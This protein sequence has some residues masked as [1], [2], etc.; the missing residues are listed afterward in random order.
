MSDNGVNQAVA[1]SSGVNCD[2]PLSEERM[3]ISER[4]FVI[5]FLTSLLVA[6]PV[7]AQKQ[8]AQ[9]PRILSAKSVYFQN[10][11][12]SDAVGKN[13]M[14]QLKKWGKFQLVADPKL[15]DLVFLLSADPYKSGNIIFASGRTGSTDDSHIS[16]DAVP[17]YNKQ[18]PT[19]YAYLTVIDLKTGDNLWSDKH[20][21]G[22][23]LTG[24][25][26]VGER[27]IRELENQTK[28]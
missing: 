2:Y 14:A 17:N 27:L 7:L 12:G 23:L 1:Y 6:T 25:N 9:S 24:R 10:Q 11:T 13:A 28:K 3:R 8:L 4:F 26:S 15:A 19:R 18:S 20:V 5:F 16:E 21:W 22:G